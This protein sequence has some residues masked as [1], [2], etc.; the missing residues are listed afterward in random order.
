[1]RRLSL[2]TLGEVPKSSRPDLD[3]RQLTTGIVHL[4]IGGFHRAHQ[5]VHTADA[6]AATGDTRWAISAV[7]QRSPRI[8]DQLRPQDGLYALA[9]RDGT[10]TRVRVV[11]SVRE[12]LDGPSEAEEV[13]N[14]IAD[15]AVRVVTLTVTEKAY[16][17][18]PATQRL[19]TDDPEI[20]ADAAGR[21]PGTV[22]GRIAAGLHR[23]RG[24]DAG[25][26][27]V[28]SCDNLADNGALLRQAVIDYCGLLPGGEALVEWIEEQVTFPGTM[29]DR[30][31][32]A[33]TDANRTEVATTLG[34]RDEATVLAEP[35]SQWFVQDDFRGPRPA[36]ERA[37]A[38]L[39][40]DVRPYELTK[41]RTLNACHSLLAYLG[42][43]AGIDT[44]AE[45]GETDDLAGAARRLAESEVRPTLPPAEGIDHHDYVETTLHRFANPALRHTTSQVASDGSR[46]I[47]P[48]LLGTVT[49][50]LGRA[51][52]PEMATLV[53]AAW[54]RQV[55]VQ[56]TDD[57]VALEVND[58][59]APAMLRATGGRTDAAS[60]RPALAAAG[61]PDELL[62]DS[63]FTGRVE[64]WYA[65]LDRAGAR[66]T[67]RTAVR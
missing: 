48:R 59:A 22:V 46:K 15:P 18:H 28:I 3:P 8:R 63:R 60:L 14:R 32:P 27:A 34:L 53:V 1:M 49:D 20:R 43:L 6:M 39:V 21:P 67:V 29:V 51:N 10:D 66:A 38:R 33:T 41:L 56:R 4:G 5:A 25:P 7:T 19:D 61:V 2:N 45:A 12:I 50:S 40:P 17:L 36:W 30:I 11:P 47:G 9:L 44:I 52:A 35:F 23:R 13:L 24:T 26:L 55:L 54:L 31:V 42:G 58:P 62:E 64:G 16:R 65:E 57:G 37:G